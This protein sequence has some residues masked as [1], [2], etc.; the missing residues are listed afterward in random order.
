ME[1]PDCEHLR[2]EL[3]ELKEKV[4]ELE[5]WK[6]KDKISIN[7][8][9]DIWVV[10]V[11]QKDKE[12]GQVKNLKYIIYHSDVILLKEMFV[13]F[14]KAGKTELKPREDVWAKLIETK[15][16][17]ISLDAFNGGRNRAKYYFIY[18]YYPVKILEHE[19][20]INYGGNGTITLKPEYFD[21][22]LLPNSY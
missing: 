13:D 20:L 7:R 10:E 8:I 16:L 12:S 4:F 15:H 3:K 5:S 11:H 2:N 17:N 18:Y 9:D 19:G 14:Y 1:C 6:G 21:F 22:S